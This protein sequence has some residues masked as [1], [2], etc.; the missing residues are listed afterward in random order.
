MDEARIKAIARALCR[1][2]RIDPDA[3]LDAEPRL[4][5]MSPA[6][7]PIPAWE[8]FRSAAENYCQTRQDLRADEESAGRGLKS[9]M[10]G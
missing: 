4:G 6:M 10:A 8:R 1:S 5:L 3:I 2:A 9:T 7:E